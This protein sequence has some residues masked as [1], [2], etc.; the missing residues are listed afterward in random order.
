MNDVVHMLALSSHK[1]S[2]MT[3][4][5]PCARPRRIRIQTRMSGQEK[6][7]QPEKKERTFDEGLVADS[8]DWPY[9]GVPQA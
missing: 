5:P 4:C 3:K 2:S 9:L 1:G 8:R 7:W 6:S